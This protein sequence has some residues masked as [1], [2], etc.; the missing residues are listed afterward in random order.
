MGSMRSQSHRVSLLVTAM[1]VVSLA[2]GAVLVAPPARAIVAPTAPWSPYSSVI[3]GSGTLTNDTPTVITDG[4][5]HIYVFYYR[6]A[7]GFVYNLYVMKYQ[8]KGTAG[9]LSPVAGFP[10][11]VNSVAN[12]VFDNAL[13]IW[14]PAAAVDHSGTVYAVWRT[15]TPALSLFLSKSTNGGLTWNAQVEVNPVGWDGHNY[16][17]TLAV[18]PNGHVYVAWTGYNPAGSGTFYNTTVAYST[19]GGATFSAPKNISASWTAN[20]WS[21]HPSIAVDSHNRVYV[22]W[23]QYTSGPGYP[24]RVNYSYSD[25]G[26]TWSAPVTLNG[27]P[28]QG[29]GPGI[30]V[31][32]QDKVDVF[33]ADGRTAV[34]GNSLIYYRSSSDRGATWSPEMPITTGVA[35]PVLGYFGA[36]VRAAVEGDALRV[37]WDSIFGSP[38]MSSVLSPNDGG[39][40]ASE[41]LR[42]TSST[43][44]IIAA[45]GNG[46]FYAFSTDAATT[47]DSIGVTWWHSPPSHATITSVTPGTGSLTVSWSAPP[48]GDVIAYQVWRSS[49][50]STYNLV[51][52]VNAPSTS[53]ADSG[54]ANGTYWYQ[55]YAVDAYGYVGQASPS[56]LGV[57]GP[58]TAQLVANLQSEISA[59]QAQ[60]TA[61]NA[62]SA[63]AIAAAQAQITSLQTQLTNL[64]N[65]QATS[66]AA[67]AAALARLQANLTAVQNQLNNLQGQQATQTISY[68][69]LAFEVIVVVLL[70]VLLLNQMRKPKVPQMMMAEPAQTPKKPEDDL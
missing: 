44:A 25:D 7:P 33:W 6:E 46:T 47:V 36:D 55:V 70:V 27:G 59:L 32:A 52:T 5:N 17:P 4:A 61:A 11:Q 45:D 8:D 9:A 58:T 54:L 1:I 60:L 63:A 15:T 19:D 13:G 10:V 26:V 66:N 67:D 30:V 37:V 34:S 56:A 69:N 57:V 12:T 53:Y 48:E 31:D 40:W 42:V 64:Q 43:A 41:E 2:L 35:N 49:D 23:S 62:S 20:W 50:G 51:A 14:R 38:A 39:T 22:V 28:L 16:Q 24:A 68:A 18:A 3:G 65:S 21:G 29:T